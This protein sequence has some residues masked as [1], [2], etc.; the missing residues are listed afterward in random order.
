LERSE[1][2]KEI[3]LENVKRSL[4]RPEYRW[5]NDIKMNLKEV[6]LEDT[7][8]IHLAQDRDQWRVFIGLIPNEK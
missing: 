4:G 2:H 1:V 6:G 5:K 7:D 8:R 3:W